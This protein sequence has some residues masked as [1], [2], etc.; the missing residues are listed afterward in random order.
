MYI[1]VMNN[2]SSGELYL[3][4]IFLPLS[5]SLCVYPSKQGERVM[6][7]IT[8]VTM[9]IC[10]FHG[11]LSSIYPYGLHGICDDVVHLQHDQSYMGCRQLPI[12]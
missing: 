4:A 11:A 8:F 9:Y 7:E 5:L 3:G 1:R 2:I 10:T 6:S 12:R